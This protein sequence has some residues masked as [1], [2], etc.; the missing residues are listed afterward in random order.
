MRASR[1]GRHEAEASRGRR[2]VGEA[3]IRGLCASIAAD[4]GA[5]AVKAYNSGPVYELEA[6]EAHKHGLPEPTGAEWKAGFE[7]GMTRALVCTFYA[8]PLT[9][10]RDLVRVLDKEIRREGKISRQIAEYHDD[11]TLPF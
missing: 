9:K 2:I 7:H 10:W 4:H 8:L 11:G 5:V 1:Y 6:Y 3:E